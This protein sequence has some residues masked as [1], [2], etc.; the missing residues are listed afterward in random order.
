MKSYYGT[1]TRNF[2]R[3]VDEVEVWEKSVEADLLSSITLKKLADLVFS[4]SEE[5]SLLWDMAIICVPIVY[6]RYVIR[7]EMLDLIYKYSLLTADD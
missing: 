1:C 2:G 7:K 3:I 5:K 6:T 4:A